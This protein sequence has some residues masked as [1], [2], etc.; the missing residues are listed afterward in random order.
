MSIDNSVAQRHA[1]TL[2]ELVATVGLEET[3][4]YLRRWHPT[5]VSDRDLRAAYE[6]VVAELVSL[7]LR[8]PHAQGNDDL[9]ALKVRRRDHREV[10]GVANDGTEYALDYVDWSELLDL[11]V[12]YEPPM[13]TAEVLASVLWEITFYGFSLAE[14]NARR[15]ELLQAIEDDEELPGEAFSKAVNGTLGTRKA[16][17]PGA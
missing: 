9:V 11:L 6:G 16:T 5:Q 2:R 15:E 3:L 8:P 10:V 12:W 7:P 14:V 1:P 4:P 13:T 17:E